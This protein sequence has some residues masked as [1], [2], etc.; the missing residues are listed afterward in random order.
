MATLTLAPVAVPAQGQQP[1]TIS[2]EQISRYAEIV[3][4]QSK[5]EEQQKALRLELIQ[6]HHSGAQQDDSSPYLL[7]FVEQERKT[8]DWKAAALALAAQFMTQAQTAVWKV[9]TEA[10]APVTPITQVRVK[11]NAVFAGGLK[12]PAASVPRHDH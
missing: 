1:R 8:V 2:S 10:A 4:I 3:A 12:R 9:Q 7:S 5:L 11:P 6:L